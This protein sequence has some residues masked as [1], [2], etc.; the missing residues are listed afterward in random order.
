MNFQYFPVSNGSSFQ[1]SSSW[2]IQVAISVSIQLWKWVQQN[3]CSYAFV[4]FFTSQ[5]GIHCFRFHLFICKEFWVLSRDVG[6]TSAGQLKLSIDV[7]LFS[8]TF[9]N[10]SCH[11][12]NIHSVVAETDCLDKMS[13]SGVSFPYSLD[14]AQWKYCVSEARKP[15]QPRVML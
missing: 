12:S 9:R 13:I 2:L 7:L 1:W 6:L 5:V 3:C 8:S 11:F 14:N 15:K 10:E 4:M